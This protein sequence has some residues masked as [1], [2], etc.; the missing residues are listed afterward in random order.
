M[1]KKNFPQ[2]SADPVSEKFLRYSA[3]SAGTK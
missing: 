1:I 3:D 2:I